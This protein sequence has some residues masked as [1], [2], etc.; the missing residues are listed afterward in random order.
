MVDLFSGST[1]AM[2]CAGL[3]A[4]GIGGVGIFLIILYFRNK[5]KAKASETWPRTKGRINFT[6]VRVDEYEDEDSSKIRYIPVVRYE[7]HVGGENYE[8]KRIS[9]G[10]EPS[11]VIRK[12]ALQFLEVYPEGQ[13]VDVFYNPEKPKEAVLVQKIRSMTAAL[14]VGIV[15]V[16]LMVCFLCPVS[17]GV[18]DLLFSGT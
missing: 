16:V 9:F 14:I 4:F 3:I 6:D 2:V 8:S 12:K 18:F 17:F 1:V 11:F 10:S 13:E 7:Y 5:Q 15:L